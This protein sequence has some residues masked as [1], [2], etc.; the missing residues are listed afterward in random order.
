MKKTL[1]LREERISTDVLVIGAGAGGMMA[2]ISAADSGAHVTLCEKGNVRR[3]GGLYGGNDHFVCYIP[4]IHGQ[5]FR[6]NFIRE[7]MRGIIDEDQVGKF[8]DLT[9]NVLQKWESWGANMKINGHY[10]YTG[11]AW[12]GSS[13]KMGERGKTN[14][15]Y[16]HFSDNS[17]CAK[18]EKQ[19]RGRNV[20]IM[21]RVMVT[22]LIKDTHAR[23][24]GAVGISTREPI[25]Y[26]F[27]AK[28]VV[29][30]KG[31]VDAE[32]LYPPPHI[33]AY[34]MAMPGAGDGVVMAYRAGADI[35]NAE[36]IS[37]QVSLRFG[38][39]A[40]KGTWIGIVKDSEG[41]SIAPP[42]LDKPDAETGDL[43][44]ENADALDNA[45]ATGKGP[46]WMDPRGISPEDERYMRMGFESEALLPFLKWIDQEKIDIRN[47][48]FEFVGMQPRTRIH[49]RVDANFKS[50]IEGL[51]AVSPGMLSWS[52][53][54]GMVAGEAAAKDAQGI[55]SQDPGKFADK[56]LR[57]KQQYEGLMNRDGLQY[58][59]WR[60]AQYAVWQIMHCYALPP[61]RTES[62]LMAGYNQLLRV[63]ERAYK[64]LKASNPHDL[65]HSLEVLNL[66][67]IAELVLLAVNERKESRDQARRQDY[68]FTNPMLNKFL[69]ITQKNGKPTFRWESP[70][71]ISI[72]A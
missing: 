37:R 5:A 6:E 55:D 2:A 30:N 28:S 60:E 50:T 63:R 17:L 49:I 54:G 12:P 33:I 16:L 20:H 58:S 13:G 42:Y 15:I 7:N 46:V 40:G 31:G 38:P 18:L 14:R 24:I 43:A 4:E 10:E 65:Y 41:H 44:I 27:Q 19:V 36:F 9:Y 53:V 29:I 45:W 39:R 71:R 1:I 34:G 47:T 35:Q 66:M 59:D 32:R 68:P 25:L 57:L 21:N 64:I 22:D 56:I 3:S 72:K 70:R 51:Y 48:R 8:V 69:V 11:H 67:D 62:T 23:V 26:I 52:A 61:H